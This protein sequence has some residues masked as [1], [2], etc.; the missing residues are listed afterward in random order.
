MRYVAKAPRE[1]INV[2]DTHPL[3]EASLLVIGLG[4]IAAF[5]VVVLVFLVEFSLYFVSPEK[6]AAIFEDWMPQDLSTVAPEDEVLLATSTLV[7]RLVRHWPGAPYEFRVEIS[8]SEVPN[9]MALPGGLIVVTQGLL[10]QVESENELAFVLAH[11]LG[12][13]RNRDHIRMLGRGAVVTLF[14]AMILG[15]DASGIGITVTDVTLRSFGREQETDADAFALETVNAEYGHTNQAARLFERWRQADK[16]KYAF[17][18]Y[19]STHPAT[20]NRIDALV[21]LS[22]EKG[23]ATTGPIVALP[24]RTDAE[25]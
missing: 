6:E 3:A 15:N 4:I 25:H 11:E 14:F 17:V 24:W 9:A 19:L 8:D 23:W 7:Q 20:A 16:D 22:G 2:S 18:S 5:V 13:F 10:D 12:H 21:A 1:G